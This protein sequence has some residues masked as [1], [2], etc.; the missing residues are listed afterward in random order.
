[1]LR[2]RCVSS[3]AQHAG[4]GMGEQKQERADTQHMQYRG[5]ASSR[6]AAGQPKARQGWD[7]SRR[8]RTNHALL[9]RS[10]ALGADNI[11]SCSRRLAEADYEERRRACAAR[12][13]VIIAAC[14]W[15]AASAI[16]RYCHRVQPTHRPGLSNTRS[17]RSPVQSSHFRSSDARTRRPRYDLD[18]ACPGTAKRPKRHNP[19]ALADEPS[20]RHHLLRPPHHPPLLLCS[21]N[22][23]TAPMCGPQIPAPVPPFLEKSS[24]RLTDEMIPSKLLQT[25]RRILRL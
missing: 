17:C 14:P 12:W 4:A 7:C 15:C 22:C 25:R 1:M 11:R 23:P 16:W 18:G 19:A 9:C 5:R 24:C 13:P 3:L 20:S 10:S 21:S 2:R 8:S 6:E